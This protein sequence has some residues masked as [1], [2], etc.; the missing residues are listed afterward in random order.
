MS[1]ILTFKGC[2]EKKVFRS[3]HLSGLI[4]A[5]S[6]ETSTFC[7][8]LARAAKKAWNQDLFRSQLPGFLLERTGKRTAAIFTEIAALSDIL[9]GN[10]EDFQL[11]LGIEGPEE[12]GKDLASKIDSF[13][14]MINRVKIAFPECFCFCHHPT[15]G[16][17]HQ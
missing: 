12:G 2:S 5:F 10:E 6:P 9:V 1:R 4:A 17:Q 8:E 15:A 16:Y 11:C 13:K 7:L 3:L 14:V